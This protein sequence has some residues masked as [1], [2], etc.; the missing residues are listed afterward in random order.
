[1]DHDTLANLVEDLLSYSSPD[2]F[3]TDLEEI[4]AL[5]AASPDLD[6]M[7]YQDRSNLV[8]TFRK[9]A[10]FFRALNTHIKID[11]VKS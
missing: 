4:A 6:G 1:M 5:A 2:M 7:Q 10:D 3:L 8:L 9:L 11:Q